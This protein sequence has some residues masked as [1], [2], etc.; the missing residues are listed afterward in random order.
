[1][2]YYLF[3]SYQVKVTV[4]LL[5]HCLFLVVWQLEQV[6][7]YGKRFYLPNNKN[8]ACPLQRRRNI[9]YII[10]NHAADKVINPDKV[11]Y[12]STFNP[13]RI[14]IDGPLSPNSAF[15][16]GVVKIQEGRDNELSDI[17]KIAVRSLLAENNEVEEVEGEDSGNDDDSFNALDN[18]DCGQRNVGANRAN[19]AYINCSFIFGSCAEVE[20]LW[21]VAKNILTDSRKGMMDPVM[22]ETIIF[23]KL[24]RRLW[25]INDFVMTG[26]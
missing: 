18:D 16:S 4:Y 25:N 19:A 11:F 1:M 5:L 8:H 12:W 2:D 22:I 26:N 17:E 9:D 15:E 7:Q 14:L 20:R 13:D 3:L 23:L 21:S 6:R 10:K 24:N